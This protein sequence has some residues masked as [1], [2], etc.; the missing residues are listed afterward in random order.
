MRHKQPD[1]S[2]AKHCLDLRCQSKRGTRLHPDDIT[3]CKRMFWEFPEWYAK[4]EARVFNMTVPFGSN[5]KREGEEQ[6]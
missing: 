3:F 4:T 5:V 2:D 1:P 6:E